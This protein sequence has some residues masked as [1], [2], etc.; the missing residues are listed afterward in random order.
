MQAWQTA[1]LMNS[2]GNFSSPV[3]VNQLLGR[4]ESGKERLPLTEEEKRER[5]DNLKK[6][7]GK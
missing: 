7:F 1:H 2:T 3:T 4:D 6:R 5:L